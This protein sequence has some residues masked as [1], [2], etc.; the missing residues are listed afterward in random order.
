MSDSLHDLA[1][2]EH[3]QKLKKA[4][5]TAHSHAA[6]IRSGNPTLAQQPEHP[7][8]RTDSL[9]AR[10]AAHPKPERKLRQGVNPGARRQP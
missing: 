9:K 3:H 7:N 1:K 8:F 2:K 6:K 4:A 10:G 5:E